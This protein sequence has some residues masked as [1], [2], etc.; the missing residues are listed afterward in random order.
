MKFDL[1][2]PGDWKIKTNKIL[3]HLPLRFCFEEKDRQFLVKGQLALQ[4]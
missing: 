2:L 3:L 1:N 4:L